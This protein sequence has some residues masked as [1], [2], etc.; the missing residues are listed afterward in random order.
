V[1]GDNA[2]G[3][4]AVLLLIIYRCVEIGIAAGRFCVYI[5]SCS[6]I[7]SVLPCAKFILRRKTDLNA[8]Q[9]GECLY[10][11]YTCTAE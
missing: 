8:V 6:Y 10:S 5:C 2:G 7:Q 11:T 4:A 1:L 3:G 9:H